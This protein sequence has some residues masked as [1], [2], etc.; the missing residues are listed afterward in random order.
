[1][2]RSTV[3]ALAAL[4]LLA[5]PVVAA[6]KGAPSAPAGASVQWQGK[7]YVDLGFKAEFPGEPQR[8][9]T[10]TDLGKDDKG[11]EKGL[12]SMAMFIAQSKPLVYL[13][14]RMDMSKSTL[15]M[16]G[17]DKSFDAARDKIKGGEVDKDG[18]SFGFT[19]GPGHEMIG[20]DKGKVIRVRMYTAGK[21]MFMAIVGAETDDE[22]LV[23]SPEADRFLN[24]FALLGA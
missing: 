11:G 20:H 13:V 15:D 6:P 12:M 23:K 14:M 8:V 2:F 16:A 24:S 9:D 17:I 19:G 4:L 3:A 22:A 5:A 7:S 18:K 10:T 21:V 1:M